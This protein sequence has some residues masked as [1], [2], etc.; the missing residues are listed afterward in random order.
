MASTVCEVIWLRW[1]LQ[2]F[3]VIQVGATPL[4]CDNDAA[5]HIAVNYVYIERTKR[6]EMDCYFVRAWVADGEINHCP[7]HFEFQIA[8]IFTKALGVDRSWFLY[9]KLGVRDLYG[10]IWE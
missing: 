9:I 2:D 6:V 10:P 8:D 4:T 1:L 3:R 5:R 7:V